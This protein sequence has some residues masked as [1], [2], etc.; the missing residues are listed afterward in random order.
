VSGVSPIPQ[1]ARPHQGRRAGLVTRAVAATVDLMV[2]VLATIG[3]YLV[4]A[5]AV[6]LLR[7]ATFEFP[8]LPF[9]LGLGGILLVLILY[10]AVAWAATGRSVGSGVMGL[11][12]INR[13]GRRPR[14]LIALLRAV[15]SVG[16]PLGLLWCL[17]GQGRRSVQDVICGT[18]VVYDWSSGS[19]SGS[20]MPWIRPSASARSITAGVAGVD[21]AAGADGIDGADAETGASSGG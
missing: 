16:V 3:G 2:A 20:S 19:A 18:A 4:V 14:P 7:P 1:E 13:R 21:G 11:R 5:G 10:L 15:L 17:V 12:V 8:R 6:F 9:L